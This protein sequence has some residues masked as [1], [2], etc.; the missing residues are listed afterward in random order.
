MIVVKSSYFI[1]EGN[2]YGILEKVNE[3]MRWII[4]NTYFT[5]LN[6]VWNNIPSI[7][8]NSENPF[9]LYKVIIPPGVILFIC[10]LFL[11]NHRVLKNKY[12][13]LQNNIEEE[14]E[15]HSMR[16]EAGIN[17]VSGHATVDVI[18]S[19]ASI[20]DA[21]WHNTWW[22]RVIIGLLIALI[23]VVIGLK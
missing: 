19:N 23:A 11:N 6:F 10:F 22:G 8:S 16:K 15:L 4:D 18:I 20:T 21:L 17:T 5:P 12:N 13:N 14:K 1:T 3:I 7:L 9:L 2:H